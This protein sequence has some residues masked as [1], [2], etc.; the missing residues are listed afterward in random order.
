MTSFDSLL[1][2][3]REGGTSC[4]SLLES[5]P[6]HPGLLDVDGVDEADPWGIALHDERAGAGPVSEEPDAAHQCAVGDAGGGK[7]NALP[8]R[9]IPGGVYPSRIG[10]H[11]AAP[12]F[13]LGLLEHEASENFAVQATHGRGRE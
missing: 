3:I 5:D 2:V 12:C 10:A 4:S 6:D 7:H 1:T 11:R 13:V 8:R 9:Q